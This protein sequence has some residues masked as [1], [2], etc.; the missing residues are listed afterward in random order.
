[1][2][3]SNPN[4]SSLVA[5]VGSISPDAHAAGTVTTA[6]I[7]AKDA[8]SYMAIIAAGTLGAAA[9]LDAK[10]EQATDDI[11]TGAKDITG[12]AIT[13]LVKAT[14]DDDQAIINI[15]QQD[16]D[17]QNDFSHFR[18]SM[19]IGVATSDASAQVF[20]AAFRNGNGSDNDLA[21]VV[22]VV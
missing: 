6:W 2:T 22:E 5:L 1:M 19:T 4:L 3:N 8:F 9:T 18:L 12:F 14:N 11:G 10:L 20:S 21:S 15:K 13:Q 17:V 16:L 7:A